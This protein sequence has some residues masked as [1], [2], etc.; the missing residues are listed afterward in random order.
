MVI[1]KVISH[2][3]VLEKIGRGGLGEVFLGEDTLLNRRVA[4]KSP[5]VIYA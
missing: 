3:R 2:Y 4:L 1:G 5:F